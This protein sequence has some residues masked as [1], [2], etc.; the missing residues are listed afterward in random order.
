MDNHFFSN[1]L[2]RWYEEHKRDLPWRNSRNPYFIWLSEILLQQTRVSQGLP[3]YE[4]FVNKYPDVFALASASETEVLKLWE[5]LGYYS[6]ARNLL[7]TAQFL[8][9]ENNGIFP[10]SYQELLKLTGIGPY[11][12]AAIAS[13]AFRE[14]VAVVDGNVYRVLSRVF[15][16]KADIGS[17]SGIKKFA[18]LAKSLLPSKKSDLYNQAIMEFGALH[19]TPATPKCSHCPVGGICYA[20]ANNLQEALPVKLKKIKKSYRY[21]NYV[22]FNYKDNFYLKKRTDKDI[23]KGLYEFHLIEDEKLLRAE[24]VVAK[25]SRGKPA[26][27]TICKESL[28]YKH[29]LSH[30]TIYAK[31]WEIK[32]NSLKFKKLIEEEFG[33]SGFTVHALAEIPKPVLINNFLKEHIF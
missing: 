32:I 11:T 9:K 16:E 30:Q 33:V 5:G 13:F 19:C 14:Q 1:T 24:E 6:R 26:N 20:R 8:V 23:W 15:G 27:L 2:L 3:Y 25:I 28:E 21:F 7:K 4:K 12:A 17:G 22:L 10:D 18:E 29:L 31:I